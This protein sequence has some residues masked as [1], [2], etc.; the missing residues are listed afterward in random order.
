MFADPSERYLNNPCGSGE[1]HLLGSSA[2]STEHFLEV[3]AI[4][5]LRFK[6]FNMVELQSVNFGRQTL[7]HL[8]VLF[9]YNRQISEPECAAVLGNISQSFRPMKCWR[10]TKTINS[11]NTMD[12]KA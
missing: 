3:H 10:S 1:S 9:A 6:D 12:N 8:D 5:M 7:N 4:Q 2:L 11:K